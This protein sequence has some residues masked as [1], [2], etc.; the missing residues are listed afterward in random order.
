[1][2]Y[3]KLHNYL[4]AEL[5]IIAIETEIQEIVEIVKTMI[6][7]EEAKQGKPTPPTTEITEHYPQG[8]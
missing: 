8:C 3:Q 7:E 2:N 5:G 1:M 4:A 6:V